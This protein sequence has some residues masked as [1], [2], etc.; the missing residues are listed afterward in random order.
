MSDKD[1]NQSGN[2]KEQ[3]TPKPSIHIEKGNGSSHE[4][5]ERSE[6]TERSQTTREEWNKIDKKGQGAGDRPKRD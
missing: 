1:K 6:R 5:L 3:S 2:N 4:R